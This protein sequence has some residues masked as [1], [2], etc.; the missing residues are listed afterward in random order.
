MNDTHE[1][2]VEK[3]EAAV[4]RKANV[5]E[6]ALYGWM[7]V[8]SV[9]LAVALIAAFLSIN[10][11]ADTVSFIQ[12]SRLDDCR[13]QNTRHNNTIKAFDGEIK[14][15]EQRTPKAQRAAVTAQLTATRSFT[16]TLIDAL[17]PKR[18]C[19]SLVGQ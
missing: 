3:L 10:H 6:V 15:I 2:H 12:Q 5:R 7:L 16:V 19:L 13:A 1:E 4:V 11:N 8:L 17:Q 14:L 18:S 9:G